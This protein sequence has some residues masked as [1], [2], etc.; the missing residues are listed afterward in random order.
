MAIGI[1][2]SKASAVYDYGT[3]RF[4]GAPA[5]PGEWINRFY[6]GE[7]F[8]CQ[9]KCKDIAP[10]DTQGLLPHIGYLYVF[11]DLDARPYKARVFYYEGEPDTIVD[12]FNGK[13]E[14]YFAQSWTMSFFHAEEDAEGHR[15][16]GVPSSWQY[17]GEVPR[18]FLQYDPLEAPM[19]FLDGMDGFA[20]FLYDERSSRFEH[21]AY[22][23]EYS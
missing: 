16:M 8:F 15:L 20:Y 5:I 18:V 19:G 13:A 11:L 17:G 1:K 9:I 3:S 12:D 23:E 6:D 2:V 21:I 4:F 22:V 14:E 7:V 10:Y